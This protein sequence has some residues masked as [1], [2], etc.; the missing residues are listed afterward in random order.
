MANSA[1][2]L[3]ELA[4]RLKGALE[5][6]DLVAFGNLLDP[7]VTWGAPGDRASAC[8]NRRQVLAW[9]E[10]GRQSALTATVSELAVLG[11]R[12]LVGLVVTGRKEPHQLSRCRS[13]AEVRLKEPGLG[14]DRVV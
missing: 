5:A 13:Y 8:Q 9:Y 10:Q 6:A 2:S 14:G 11:E 4:Q 3:E 12:I 7:E 1:E